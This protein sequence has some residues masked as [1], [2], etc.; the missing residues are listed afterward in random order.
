VR[1]AAEASERAPGFGE[2]LGPSF[3]R[4]FERLRR[5]VGRPGIGVAYYDQLA[6]DGSVLV[7]LGVDIGDDAV[8]E[9]RLRDVAVLRDHRLAQI[10]G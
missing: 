7:H 4:L 1:A 5:R 10:L 6:D 8:D 9:E 2:L 3:R